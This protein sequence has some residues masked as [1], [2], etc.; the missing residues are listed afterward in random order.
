[1]RA[2]H[3]HP[4]RP[5][6]TREPNVLV[7]ALDGVIP[8]EL[9]RATVLVVAPA[10]NSWLR[11]W[12]SDE[13]EARRRAHERMTAWV[14]DLERRGVRVA[15]HVGDADPLQAIADALSTF[16]ADEIVIAGQRERPARRVDD[17]V[18]RARDRFALPTLRTGRVIPHAA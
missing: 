2:P 4:N 9:P 8:T 10:L 13:D 1:M 5:P 6:Q 16:R 7:V 17:L 11:R 12:L 14:D 18:Q 3:H 15:G